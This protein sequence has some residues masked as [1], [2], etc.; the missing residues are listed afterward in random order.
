MSQDL[1][2]KY[3]NAGVNFTSGRHDTYPY[4]DPTHNDLNGK[5]VL[6]TGAS[7]G[8]GKA[9]ALSYARSGASGIALGARSPLEP[10]VEEVL[11][12]AKSAGRP[13]PRIVTLSLDVTDRHSVEA[14]AQKISGIFDGR[15]DIL[16]N[17]AG[18]LSKCVSILDSDPDDWWRGWEVN[19]KGVY[20]VT[21]AFLPLLLKSSWKTVINISSVGA[22]M[23]LQNNSAYGSAKLASL[24]FTE[25][26]SQDHGEGT[27]GVIAIAVHPGHVRTELAMNLPEHLYALLTD[28]PELAG[29]TLAWVGRERREWLSGRYVSANWDMEE[30]IEKKEEI[31]RGDLLK[32]RM[33]IK[34]PS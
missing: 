28:S 18:H 13:E 32:V 10:V 14:A 9:A 15:L 27:D 1:E 2:Q 16:I 5:Y 23:T 31:I 29:D 4:I 33:A 3:I 34:L 22:V 11:A 20:L 25:Y 19:V 7:K 8:L 26:I 12:A 17:N 24:R 30:F 6:I 21:R